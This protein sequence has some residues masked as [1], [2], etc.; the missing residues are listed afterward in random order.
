MTDYR[1]V[2]DPDYVVLTRGR[3]DADSP[4][5]FVKAMKAMCP[6]N[7]WQYIDCGYD[8]GS[9]EMYVMVKAI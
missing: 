2:R 4:Q 1:I 7:G 6:L 5:Q 9:N 8:A 3:I